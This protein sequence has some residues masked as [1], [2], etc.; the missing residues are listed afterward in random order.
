M[1]YENPMKKRCIIIYRASEK[2][3]KQLMEFWTS[4]QYKKLLANVNRDNGCG[5]SPAR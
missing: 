5:E 1:Q 2:R 4:T 3:G